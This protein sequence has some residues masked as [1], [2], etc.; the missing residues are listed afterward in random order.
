M[1]DQEHVCARCARPMRH[2][3]ALIDTSCANLLRRHLEDVAKIAGDINLTVAR[4]DRIARGAGPVDDLGWWK[5]PNALEAMP[6]LPDLDRAARHDRAVN[7]IST[8][9][10]I[11]IEE[12]GRPMPRIWIGY[13]ARPPK[14]QHPLVELTAWLGANLDWLRHHPEAAQAWTDLLAACAELVRIVDTRE[15]GELIGLC[16]CG[17]ARYSTETVCPRCRSEDLEHDRGALE[18]KTAQAIVT[19][20]EAARWVVDMGLV[21]DSG[22]LRKLIWAWADRGH[23]TAVDDVPRYRFGDVLQRVMQSPALRAA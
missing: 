21:L 17:T 12:R 11:V 14:P 1:T 7:E 18:A 16:S 2:D 22:K 5:E 8:W 20:S 15:P 9:A 13:I 23:L 6:L 19:A 4:L 3:T 10:R